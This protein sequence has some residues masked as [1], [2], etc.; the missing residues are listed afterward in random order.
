MNDAEAINQDLERDA[1]AV[2]RALSPL[3]RRAFYPPGIPHQATE[4]RGTTYNGTIGQITDGAGAAMP[5][6]SM[7]AALALPADQ[8]SRAFL[9]SPVPGRPEVREA[10]RRWQ[11]RGVDPRVPSTLPLVTN[12]LT[13]ALSIIADLFTDS[14]RVL[15]VPGPFWGNYRQVFAM[16]TGARIR[17]APTMRDGR[18]NPRAIAEVLA[19][20]PAGEPAVAI[21]NAP[22]N[23]GGYM[24]SAAEREALV[25]SLLEVAAM[26]PLVVLLDDAYAGLVYDDAPRQSLFWSLA[27]AHPDLLA[28]KIDGATKEL[29]FFGGRLG[30]ITFGVAAGSAVQAA[31]ESK[32][33]SLVRSTVGSPVAISQVVAHQALASADLEAQVERVRGELALRWQALR[34]ALA[35]TDPALLRPVPFNAGCFA[36][37]ALPDG[38]DAET[39]RR[40]LIAEQDTGLVSIPPSHV[41]IAFCSVAAADLPELVR[42]LA[43]G[44]ETLR[45]AG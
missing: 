35:A 33:K 13:H 12:G 30:F 8:R 4:A 31:L 45:A 16:R 40:H 23:P 2:F 26:R 25:A 19:D 11:R 38:V 6:A 15:A 36:V 20:L 5:L 44:V 32:V 3:G 37:V 27:G 29:S 28:V 39:L 22:S 14:Q 18:Y 21:V 42:R 10:W 41:R 43:A 7:A 24:P 9:Y 17:S 34:T 1:P